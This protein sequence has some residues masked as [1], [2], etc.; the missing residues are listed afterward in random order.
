M[1]SVRLRYIIRWQKCLRDKEYG[2]LI[3]TAQ[4]TSHYPPPTITLQWGAVIRGIMIGGH[5]DALSNAS[6]LSASHS[7]DAK[8]IALMQQECYKETG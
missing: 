7:S 1:L 8:Q 6:S 5:L 2:S 4:G 3:Y